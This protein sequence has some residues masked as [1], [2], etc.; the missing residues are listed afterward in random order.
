ML[1][2]L[3]IREIEAMKIP[4][5]VFYTFQISIQGVGLRNLHV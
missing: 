1:C 5:Q 4:V 2:M 3:I